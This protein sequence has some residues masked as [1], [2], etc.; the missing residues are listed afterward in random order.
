[1]SR[2]KKHKKKCHEPVPLGSTAA[3]DARLSEEQLHDEIAR[4]TTTV[5]TCSDKIIDDFAYAKRDG[6]KA[7]SCSSLRDD[8]GGVIGPGLRHG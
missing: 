7:A 5:F 8:G 6:R 3:R 2:A 1:M 4:D